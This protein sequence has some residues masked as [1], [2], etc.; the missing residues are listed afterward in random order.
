VVVLV[1]IA[2]SNF[3]VGTIK[4]ALF[5][6]AGEINLNLI[7]EVTLGVIWILFAIVLFNI[8]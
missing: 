8:G 3:V 5:L 6:A 1:K 2:M 7:F 4:S